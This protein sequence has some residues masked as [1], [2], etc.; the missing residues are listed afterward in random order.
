[1]RPSSRRDYLRGIAV[2]SV[3]VIAGCNSSSDSED[4]SPDPERTQTGQTKTSQQESLASEV[5]EEWMFDTELN[6]SLTVIGSPTIVDGTAYT[7]EFNGSVYA[8]DTTDGTAE[9][10]TSVGS[11]AST[12]A[13]EGEGVYAPSRG[14]VHAFT[15]D[16]GSTEW[17]I[18]VTGIAQHPT[19]SGETVYLGTGRLTANSDCRA[20]AINRSDGSKIWESPLYE[21]GLSS[22]TVGADAVYLSSYPV[23]EQE[24]F[25]YALD[26]ADGTELWS[27][28]HDQIGSV[29]AK[30]VL[31]NGTIYVTGELISTSYDGP[32]IICAIDAEDGSEQWVVEFDSTISTPP[33]VADGTVYVGTESMQLYGLETA[34]G[35]EQWSFET[36][37]SVRA[38]P[39]VVDDTVVVSLH[40]PQTTGGYAGTV[41]AVNSSDG[42][43]RW[44]HQIPDELRGDRYGIRAKP[45]I[46]EGTIY[47]GSQNGTVY[48][49]S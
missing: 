8:L 24:E 35:A 1:M 14:S 6:E 39:T 38:Q 26:P 32:S 46:G 34:T 22:P 43:E 27:Y 40:R 36:D 47:V 49:L 18:D 20:Y 28:S 45:T 12:P 48:A 29:L 44:R 17:S 23:F 3:S 7:G 9:W 13:V 25:V 5:S 19:I 37:G 31:A 2:G 21:G 41:Q 42:T 33:A 11:V 15:R 10:T 16:D 4:S 30:P